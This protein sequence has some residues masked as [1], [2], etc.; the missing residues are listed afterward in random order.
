MSTSDATRLAAILVVA[1][2]CG[3]DGAEGDDCVPG[4]ELVLQAFA[5][6]VTDDTQIRCSGEPFPLAARFLCDAP[7]SP[8]VSSPG[9]CGD[10][11][12]TVR[13]HFRRTLSTGDF[14][15]L[16]VEADEAGQVARARASYGYRGDELD[17]IPFDSGS[18]AI[19][20]DRLAP[21]IGHDDCV[22]GHLRLVAGG[23]VAEGY[24]G[25]QGC[26]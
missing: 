9:V 8:Y 5:D 2:C 14:V 24:F 17:G 6:P 4:G 25:T 3:D 12:G 18:L 21:M 20:G 22:V 1:T 15:F 19:Q 11:G 10:E 7:N 13:L 26:N 23:A 16:A